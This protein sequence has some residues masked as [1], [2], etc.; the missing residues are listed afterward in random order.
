MNGLGQTDPAGRA[1]GDGAGGRPPGAGDPGPPVGFD[2]IDVA[3]FRESLATRPRLVERLFTA[4]E[5]AYCEAKPDPAPHY[6][7]R[8]AAKEA[9][10][11][12][13]GFGELTWHDVEVLAA[14]PGLAP[15]VRLRGRMAVLAARRGV[16]G[17]TVSLT[18]TATVA[19]AAAAAREEEVRTVGHAATD[20]FALVD[21]QRRAAVFSPAQV[22]ELD[23]RA[24][25]DL[26]IPGPVLMERAALGITR[27][28]LAR[29][30]G[31][32]ALIA[33]GRGN[34]G[35]DG[36]AAARQLHLAGHPVACIV[37]VAGADDLS[38]DARLNLTAAQGAGVNVRLGSAP[39]YLWDEAQLVVDCLLGTG[40][41][42]ELREPLAE[43]AR[44]V[45]DAGARGVPVVAVDVPSGVDAGDGSIATGT[46]AADCTVTFH[47]AKPGLVCPPGSEAAGEVLVWDIGLPAFLEPEPELRVVRGADV[48][49][50]GRRADDH[51][52]SAGF[53]GVV[54]G[55]T[56]YSGA[57]YL[58]AR[59]AARSGAG[60]VRLVTPAGAAAVLRDRL[61]EIVV[62]ESGPGDALAADAQLD[63]ALD[64]PRLGALVVGPGLGRARETL[65]AVRALIARGGPPVVLDADGLWAFAA[66]A[67]ALRGRGGLVLTPHAGELAQLLG[68]GVHEVTASALRAA[69]RGAEATGQVVVLKGSSTVI[70]AP[71]GRVSVVVQG[72]PQLAS[73]GTGDVLAGCVGAFLARG[74]EPYE[75]AAAACWVH[76]EAGRLWASRRREGLMAADLIELLPDVVSAHVDERRPGWRT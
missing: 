21:V 17:I 30:P 64:D 27:L 63:A 4:D 20:P 23:R 50:P 19:G 72:P 70:A 65:A 39:E 8:F 61:I 47:A 31:R 59:A 67:D 36:L 32:H 1:P 71:D 24:I 13:L 57:A 44:R 60:Y 49:V 3:R 40:A 62:V 16:V 42:G 75:A 12:L 66:D 52:Y 45:N 56:A 73:A 55:S 5:R 48:A 37:A 6:A 28:V 38:P 7:A 76:A 74:L 34:N 54:A 9:V 25:V 10:A 58:A 33:C 26:G 68:L 11:K 29:Y 14:A 15:R 2:L 18:H 53:V 22:R 43:W 35:G 46:V 51:K 41:S 69:R